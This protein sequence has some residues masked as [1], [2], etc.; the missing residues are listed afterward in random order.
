MQH[1]EPLN[2]N[3]SSSGGQ[4]M[5][6]QPFAILS[7]LCTR[8]KRPRPRESSHRMPPSGQADVPPSKAICVAERAGMAGQRG[9]S[10]QRPATGGGNKGLKKR[11]TKKQQHTKQADFQK[12]SKFFEQ[13]KN[14]FCPPLCANLGG[15]GSRPYQALG[16]SQDLR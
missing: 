7:F 5:R 9:R 13:K 15:R 1:T 2:S 12:F 10:W 6:Q 3:L 8:E 16:P 11:Q 14:T 4:I